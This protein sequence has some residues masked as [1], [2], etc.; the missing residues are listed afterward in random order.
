MNERTNEVVLVLAAVLKIYDHKEELKEKW[1][2]TRYLVGRVTACWKQPFKTPLAQTFRDT[3]PYKRCYCKHLCTFLFF[4]LIPFSSLSH[5]GVKLQSRTLSK[6][7]DRTLDSKGFESLKRATTT[8]H[9]ELS[10]SSS[11]SFIFKNKKRVT[12]LFRMPGVGSL[13]QSIKVFLLSRWEILISPLPSSVSPLKPLALGTAVAKP[14]EL[15]LCHRTVP[16][17]SSLFAPAT[18]ALVASTLEDDALRCL[19]LGE[20]NESLSF[21]GR[22]AE[23]KKEEIRE[24]GLRRWKLLNAT[25]LYTCGV[26]PN[27]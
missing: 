8:K 17:C 15:G 11:S 13:M 12:S 2:L 9:R 14:L 24:K 5:S 6:D 26:Q 20:L 1:V 25:Y 4:L 22:K 23:S 3:S 16:T 7:L 27:T 21:S 19:P 10:S 18:D